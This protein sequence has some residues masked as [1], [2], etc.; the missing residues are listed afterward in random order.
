[1]TVV[2]GRTVGRSLLRAVVDV[3]NIIKLELLAISLLIGIGEFIACVERAIELYAALR[4]VLLLAR[5]AVHVVIH[6]G[7]GIGS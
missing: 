7:K 6:H 4:E 2:N 3:A 1:M 5:D